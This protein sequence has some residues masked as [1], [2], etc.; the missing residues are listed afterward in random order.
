MTREVY[1]FR[2]SDFIP[3]GIGFTL[4]AQ[5]NEYTCLEQEGK[6]KAV[7]GRALTLF[8][9]NVGLFLATTGLAIYG[10]V[11]GLESLVN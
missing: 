4:Y 7:I 3:A 5:R 1:H 6:E 10:A 8:A 11:K 2:A 9:Y